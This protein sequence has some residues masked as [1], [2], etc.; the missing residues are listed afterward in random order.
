MGK[1]FLCALAVSA[2]TGDGDGGRT[3]LGDAGPLR[4]DAA[5]ARCEDGSTRIEIWAQLPGVTATVA[6]VSTLLD[7][8]G[9][10]LV[11]TPGICGTTT[12]LRL[13]GAGE[14]LELHADW[15]R[16]YEASGLAPETL[17]ERLT[18]KV[19]V[20]ED[21]ECGLGWTNGLAAGRGFFG[22]GPYSIGPCGPFASSD[23]R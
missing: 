8:E 21:G 4:F 10:E 6:G 15:S 1:L 22:D 7:A 14:V 18:L 23:D 12:T 13:E 20:R 5:T 16:D 2:C 19:E 3:P 11:I 9:G 17:L